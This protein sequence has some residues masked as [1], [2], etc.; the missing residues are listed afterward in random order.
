M[1]IP[2]FLKLTQLDGC[3]YNKAL[4][5]RYDEYKFVYIRASSIVSINTGLHRDQEKSSLGP[6]YSTRLTLS[7]GEDLTV[8]ESVDQVMDLLWPVDEDCR[9]DLLTFNPY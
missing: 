2:T 1:A 6:H 9:P 8:E 3:T 7:T 4:G 5:E